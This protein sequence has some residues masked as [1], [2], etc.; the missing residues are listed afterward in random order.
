MSEEYHVVMGHPQVAFAEFA[1]PLLFGSGV[2]FVGECEVGDNIAW[3][4]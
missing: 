2:S 1:L 3:P 4:W